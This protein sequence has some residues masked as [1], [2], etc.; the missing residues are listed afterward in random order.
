MIPEGHKLY[1]SIKR[2]LV[3]CLSGCLPIALCRKANDRAFL[4][5]FI[6]PSIH[7]LGFLPRYTNAHNRWS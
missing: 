1:E 3:T 4:Q 2:D 7:L 5:N 6:H